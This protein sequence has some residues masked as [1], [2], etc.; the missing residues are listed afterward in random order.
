ME[1]AIWFYVGIIGAIVGLGLL[2]SVVLINE[3]ASKHQVAQNS[4]RLLEQKCNFVCS[5]DLDTLQSV[6]VELSS[7]MVMY[8]NQTALCI[9]LQDKQYCRP[10]NCK[11]TDSNNANFRFD[12]NTSE[13]VE[14][15]STHTFNCSFEKNIGGVL[16]ACAG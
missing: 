14:L 12:L 9:A 8:S 3:N 7:G 1:Q 15:F 2:A 11:I 10:C 4:I 16:L 13:A 6:D 5:S